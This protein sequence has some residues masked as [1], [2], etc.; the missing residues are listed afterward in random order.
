MTMKDPDAIDLYV[1]QRVRARRVAMGMSQEKLADALGLTFQ[2]VQKYEKGTNRISCSKLVVIAKALRT[3]PAYFFEGLPDDGS[4][5]APEHHDFLTMMGTRHGAQICAIWPAIEA[6]GQGGL[7][8][9]LAQLVA[10]AP[11]AKQAA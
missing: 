5:P 11:G 10:T 9:T 7:I 8:V 3:H 6:A 1:G 4:A 2:Q